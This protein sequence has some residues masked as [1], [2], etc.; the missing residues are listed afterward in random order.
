MELSLSDNGFYV[1][2]VPFR[3]NFKDCSYPID[4]IVGLYSTHD[5]TITVQLFMANIFMGEYDLMSHTI[6]P[7]Q[8]FLLR[9]LFYG[10]QEEDLVILKYID[11]EPV[12]SKIMLLCCVLDNEI[13]K[14]CV[15][16]SLL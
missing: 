2:H 3:N 7:L 9:F 16:S 13:R 11:S 12:N 5:Q 14:D 6:V 15:L 1:F 10:R 4:L 8:R